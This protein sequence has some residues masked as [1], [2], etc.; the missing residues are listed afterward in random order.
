MDVCPFVPVSNVTM[1][2][3]VE[4]SSQFGSRLAN[5]LDVPVYLYE[6]A[7]QKDYRKSLSQIRHGQYEKLAERV[8]LFCQLESPKESK[9]TFIHAG[10]PGWREGS[11]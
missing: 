5:E 9:V 1:E 10:V 6:E 2:E 8:S 4:C 7:Q 11:K 3:C